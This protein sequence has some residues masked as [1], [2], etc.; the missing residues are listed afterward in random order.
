[1][2]VHL[3]MPDLAGPALRTTGKP[4]RGR[5]KEGFGADSVVS[6]ATFPLLGKH[7]CIAISPGHAPRRFARPAAPLLG[8][9]SSG[10][11]VL[12]FG[13]G[14]IVRPTR[15][16]PSSAHAPGRQSVVFPSVLVERPTPV[17]SRNA[18]ASARCA[19]GD[20]PVGLGHALRRPSTG[21]CPRSTL[22]GQAS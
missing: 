9:R 2:G 18:S 13:S 3:L 1:M 16:R 19:A 21:A 11:S 20:S 10:D 6:A 14:S 4:R 22:R 8:R 17:T 12:C 15:A 7:L 5:C